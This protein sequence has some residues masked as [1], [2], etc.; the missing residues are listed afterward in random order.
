MHKTLLTY[1]KSAYKTGDF[2]LTSGKRSDFYIDVKTLMFNSKFI[3]C[4]GMYMFN[5]IYKRWGNSCVAV[6]GMELGSVPL[7]TAT[8][9]KSNGM[10]DHYVVRKGTKA[11][12]M[13]TQIEG[14]TYIEGKNVVI[15]DDVFTTGGSLALTASMLRDHNVNCLGAFFVM[16]RQEVSHSTFPFPIYSLFTKR[17]LINT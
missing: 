6:G 8:S 4:A 13:K 17:D 12:G 9:I 5:Q 2:E 11:H 10:Y 1:L 7:S 15:V 16:D 3:T 14:L